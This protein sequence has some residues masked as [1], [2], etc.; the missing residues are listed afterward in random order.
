LHVLP[1][2]HVEFDRGTCVIYMTP[3]AEETVM[4]YEI[5]VNGLKQRVDVEGDTPLL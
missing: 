4:A 5:K 3:R 1:H 2:V